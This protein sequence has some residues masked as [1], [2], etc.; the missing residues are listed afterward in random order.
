MKGSYH[1]GEG[2]Q[3]YGKTLHA[4]MGKLIHMGKGY[5]EELLIG[6]GDGGNL[7]PLEQERTALYDNTWLVVI[8]VGVLENSVV[9]YVGCPDIAKREDRRDNLVDDVSLNSIAPAKKHL[10]ANSQYGFDELYPWYVLITLRGNSLHLPRKHGDREEILVEDGTLHPKVR[11]GRRGGQTYEMIGGKGDAQHLT[12]R[13]IQGLVAALCPQAIER[14][15]YGF[16]LPSGG[17]MNKGT[18]G[19]HGNLE[20]ILCG[21]DGH[22]ECAPVYAW[23]HF[24]PVEIAAIHMTE[25]ILQ[26]IL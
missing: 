21:G 26:C 4:L 25:T 19:K 10:W 20:G 5:L 7:W 15:H 23:W 13:G 17:G 16:C 12:D 2:N 22:E 11:L 3:R 1:K 9:P 18:H 14:C 6:G 24:Q 8:S